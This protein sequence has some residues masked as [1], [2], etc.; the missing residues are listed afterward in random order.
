M[1]SDICGGVLSNKYDLKFTEFRTRE[2]GQTIGK[3]YPMQTK[4]KFIIPIEYMILKYFNE[5]WQKISALLALPSDRS[6]GMIPFCE[7]LILKLAYMI[8]ERPQA[9]LPLM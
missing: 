9:V 2:F 8:T 4:P 1:T 6:L 5:I 7:R 3:F